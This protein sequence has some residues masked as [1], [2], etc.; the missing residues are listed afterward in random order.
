VGPRAAKMENKNV[1]VF[2]TMPFGQIL[3][4][5]ILVIHNCKYNNIQM[6]KH[7]L[8][9]RVVESKSASELTFYIDSTS[10]FTCNL[11]QS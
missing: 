11:K 2:I 6:G 9:L 10:V 4:I 1:C 5:C 3:Y 8:I 7:F